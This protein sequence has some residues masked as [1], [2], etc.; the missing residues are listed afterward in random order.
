M[1]KTWITAAVARHLRAEGVTT[2]ARKPAQSFAL[3]QL[4]ASRDAAVLAAATGEQ[5]DEVCVPGRSYELPMAPP[6]A[7][8]ALG[9]PR[10]ALA[11]LLTEL[12]WPPVDVG[13]V[14]T[15][16]GVRSPLADDGDNAALLAALSPALVVL[17]A[18]AGLGTIN[19]VRL[20]AEA[21]WFAPLLVVLNRFEAGNDLH[22]RNRAW[23]EERDGLDVAVSIEEVVMSIRSS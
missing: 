20:S 4:P 22:G 3:D 17:V 9:R 10:I 14:E 8:A 21:L 13:F 7:A 15:A 12:T 23:L 5:A 2:S 6:M 18:D 19:L 11:D 1:G 16:G